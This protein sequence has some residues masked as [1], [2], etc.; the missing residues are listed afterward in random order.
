MSNIP[1]RFINPVQQYLTL[2]ATAVL[3]GG[4]LYFYENGT[5]TPQAT[6]TDATLTTAN[7]NPVPLN[8]AGVPDTDIWMNGDYTVVLEDKNGNTI[9]TA[10]DCEVP[11]GSAQSIPSLSG[12]TGNFLTTDGT[13]LLWE[14]ISQLPA[15][16][17][18]SGK[19]LTNNG[20]TASWA[21]LALPTINAGSSG[22]IVLGA[23]TI[24]W[25]S[26]TLPA[27]GANTTTVNVNFP[28][29]F[30][31]LPY[32]VGLQQ[33]SGSGVTAGGGQLLMSAQ[34]QNANTFGIGGDTNS[35]AVIVRSTNVQ[36]L[37]IGPT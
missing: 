2:A 19:Y 22:S 31:G 25:G 34:G 27:S 6:Y 12:E 3:A 21:A 11:G 8:S 10:N 23:V 4:N 32:Y 33:T 16:T 18:Q 26:A 30:S 1:F 24:Q 17:G 35:S 28:T 20:T 9:W 15:M 13:N 29:P 36:W 37:A 14:A 7:P 5:T